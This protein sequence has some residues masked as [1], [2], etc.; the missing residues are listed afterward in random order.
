[1]SDGNCIHFLGTGAGDC[2]EMRHEAGRKD[3][4]ARKSGEK[5]TRHAPGLFIPPDILVDRFS[6][7]R[8]RACGIQEECIRH[9]LVS[10]GHQDHFQPMAMLDLAARLPK[11]LTVHGNTTVRNALDFASMHQWNSDTG[12]FEALEDVSGISITEVK[13]GETFALGDITVTAV[14]ANHMIDKKNMIQQEQALNFVLERAGKVLFYGLDTSYVLPETMEILSG[15][16]FD[17]AIIDA[18]FGHMEIDPLVSGHH[19]FDMLEKT[20]AQFRQ[21]G[22]LKDD[23]VI[24]ADHISYDA[25]EPY[26]EIVEELAEKGIVLAYDGMTL[27]L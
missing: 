7:E 5:D 15:Y 10:H 12:A 21:A 3:T 14:L 17:I 24:V 27:K 20:I 22:A 16:R 8:L 23:A 6:P 2:V 18:T 26:D 25:V 11:G 19:N 4:D 9:L 1:M 13:P